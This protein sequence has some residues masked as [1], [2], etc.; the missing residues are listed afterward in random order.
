MPKPENPSDNLVS[1]AEQLA[2]KAHDGQFRRDGKTPYIGHPLSVASRVA[3]DDAKAVAWLHDVIEDTQC[4]YNELLQA[5]IPEHV[6][7]AVQILSKTEE[8]SYE[9][10]LLRVRQNQL[11]CE[12]KIADMLSNLSDNPT[13]K[14]IIK[15][16][17]GLLFLHEA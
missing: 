16:A 15:Y 7:N 11:A 9:D 17:K 13:R 12:V 4:D 8:I 14:Q 3:S 1:L 5:G 2:T 10:Y 6:A